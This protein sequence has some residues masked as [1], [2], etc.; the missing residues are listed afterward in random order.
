MPA[1]RWQLSSRELDLTNGVLVGV[2]NVTP[3]SFSDGGEFIDPDEA[4]AHG[5]RLTAD[6]AALIDVGGEST[7]PGAEPVTVEEE[8]TRV[9]SVV[10]GLVAAGV[11]VS[12]DT[13]KPEVAEA[14]LSAGAQVVN[15]VT[16]FRHDRMVQLVTDAQCAV[17]VMHSQ[18]TPPNLHIDPSYDDVVSEVED[19]LLATTRRLSDQGVDESRI[20]I[21]PGIGFGKRPNHSLSLIAGLT[22]L[23]N[24]GF[25]VLL[26]ASRKGF[27]GE[28]VGR[29][30]ASDRDLA[31][32][33]T[34]AIG[35][36]HGARIFRVHDVATSNHALKV[37]VAIS[38]AR[39]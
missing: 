31:T 15:D 39:T 6:G 3:D 36:I 26:G 4:I 14:A 19:F 5:L 30:G 21:D 28:I 10:E 20:A 25:P 18:G 11:V 27:L 34:T 23:S 24:H 1:T 7:R 33:I 22:R 35:Y 8:K 38:A 9:M 29:R 2:V 17:V 13:Y 32:A 16:G 12:I 37:A